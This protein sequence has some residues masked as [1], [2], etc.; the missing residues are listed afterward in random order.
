MRNRDRIAAFVE[1]G[2]FAMR[3]AYRHRCIRQAASGRRNRSGFTL[4]ECISAMF[5]MALVLPAINLGIAAATKSAGTARHRT[6]AAGLASSQLAQLVA[7]G[8][9]N[10]GTMSGDFGA[11]WP[12]YHWTANLQNWVNDTQ[13]VGM[14]QL[15]VIV[16]WPQNGP[17]ESV[18]ISSLVYI[19]PTPTS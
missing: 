2:G 19:R 9:W 12:D 10:G 16:T 11:E 13:G 15:D 5:L 6:E 18:K 4:I 17:Q 3:F 14:Q 7:S 1:Q 8:Q